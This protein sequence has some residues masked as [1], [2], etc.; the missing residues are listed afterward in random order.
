MV[1]HGN[2]WAIV[3]TTEVFRESSIC[4]AIKMRMKQEDSF[5]SDTFAGYC[6]TFWQNTMVIA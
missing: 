2:R 5:Y 6:D 1:V 3:L 4:A